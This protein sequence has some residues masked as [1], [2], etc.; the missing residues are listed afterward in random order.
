MIG[1]DQEK[2]EAYLEEKGYLNTAEFGVSVMAC[3]GYR[4]QEITPKTRWK[5]E[6]IYEVIE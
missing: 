2:V 5:T 6:V 1:Y 3:F 4:N